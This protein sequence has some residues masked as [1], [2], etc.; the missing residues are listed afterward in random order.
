MK[1]VRWEL[2]LIISTTLSYGAI[3]GKLTWQYDWKM[4]LLILNSQRIHSVKR[5]EKLSS[6]YICRD[7]TRQRIYRGE[8]NSPNFGS[9]LLKK[10]YKLET[11]EA[12]P[13]VQLDFCHSGR[14]NCGVGRCGGQK[15]LVR[16][17]RG[18]TGIFPLLYRLGPAC[19]SYRGGVLNYVMLGIG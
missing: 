17:V 11:I 1:R 13:K 4:R 19:S 9:I 14:V 15:V 18:K 8:I 5:T 2:V 7:K 6:A 10:K 12:I 3:L 16:E